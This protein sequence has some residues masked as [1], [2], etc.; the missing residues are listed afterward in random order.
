MAERLWAPWRMEFVGGGGAAE[1]CLFC[2]LRDEGEED[3]KNLVLWRGENALLMLNAFPYTSGHLMA[4][5]YRHTADYASLTPDEM[6]E[7]MGL[8]QRAIRALD[9]VYQPQ[10]HNVGLNLGSAAGAGIADHLHVH[11]VPRW[12]GDTNFMHAVG[13][14]RVLPDSLE[15]SYEK[16]RAALAGLEDGAQP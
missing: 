2:R 5:P 14:T 7:L 10:G 8:T 9:A 4:A 15:S 12:V 6:V 13:N 16:L 3:E 11:V 1:G